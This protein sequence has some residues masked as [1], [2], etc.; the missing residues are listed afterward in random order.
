MPNW[1]IPLA[2][3]ALGAIS[4]IAAFVKSRSEANRNRAEV[5]ILE[6]KAPVERDSIIAAATEAAVLSMDKA[7]S[8][9][10]EDLD[11]ARAQIKTLE[12]EREEDRRTIEKL[13]DQLREVRTQAE[14]AEQAATAA[15]E[16]AEAL[17]QQL[18]RM[19]RT[20]DRRANG[21]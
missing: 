6:E 21:H 19:Q 10:R 16:Q 14:H 9:A 8:N 11:R 4:G 17:Q 15:R 1:V 12:E 7:L 20:F 18:T 3:S 2:I 13:Q 5:A